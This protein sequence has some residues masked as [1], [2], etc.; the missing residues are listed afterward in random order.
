[1]M[2]GTC[3]KIKGEGYRPTWGTDETRLAINCQLLKLGGEYMQV[4][5]TVL[6]V[7]V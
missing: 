7:Y 3:F 5:Y 2:Q 1:M 6:F 4:H